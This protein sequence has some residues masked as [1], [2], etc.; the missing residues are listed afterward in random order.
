MCKHVWA[1]AYF[2]GNISDM[3]S[4]GTKIVLENDAF[5]G[6]R[7]WRMCA[8]DLLESVWAFETLYAAIST[9]FISVFSTLRRSTVCPAD[10]FV[11]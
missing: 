9:I 7:K 1:F 6:S 8:M 11:I 2:Y 5:V 3:E 4:M 10:R